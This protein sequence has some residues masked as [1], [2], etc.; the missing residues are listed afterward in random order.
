MAYVLGFW[1]ADGS[2]RKSRSY[3]IGFYSEDLDLLEQIRRTIDSTH[4]IVKNTDGS[5]RFIVFSKKMYNNLL[6]IGGFPNKSL[7]IKFPKVPKKYLA[8][9]IRGYFDGDGSVFYTNYN[10]TKDGKPRTELRSNFTSGSQQFLEKLRDQLSTLLGL[11]SRKVVNYERTTWKLGYGTKD[12]I[13]LLKFLYHP[14][15][16]VGMKRKAGF[17]NNL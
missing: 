9:F 4:P 7:K 11:S 3:K 12:T 17:L 6:N 1:F 8:D 2:M 15:Y 10:S 5:Y 14:S 16:K 13:S